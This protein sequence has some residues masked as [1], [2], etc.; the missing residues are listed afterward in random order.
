MAKRLIGQKP[1]QIGESTSY[2][3]GE[4]VT[5]LFGSTFPFSANK[6]NT[7][8]GLRCIEDSSVQTNDTVSFISCLECSWM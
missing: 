3:I 2:Q 6:G 1:Y 8:L 4:S 7:A 5:E